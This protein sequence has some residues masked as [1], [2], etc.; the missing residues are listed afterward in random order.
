MWLTSP[1]RYRLHWSQQLQAVFLSLSA[2][3]NSTLT[4]VVIVNFNVCFWLLAFDCFDIG[5][6]LS[7]LCA[8]LR[9]A[10]VSLSLIIV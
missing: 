9:G 3:V 5:Q 4:I 10:F 1:K 6:L 2:F 7:A 8:G